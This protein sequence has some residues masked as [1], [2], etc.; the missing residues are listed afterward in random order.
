MLWELCQS[1]TIGA[2]SWLPIALFPRTPCWKRLIALQILWTS[3]RL[4]VR[5]DAVVGGNRDAAQTLWFPCAVD[6]TRTR[7]QLHRLRWL[8]YLG[9]VH[10]KPRFLEGREN[11]RTNPY[12]GRSSTCDSFKAAVSEKRKAS[13]SIRLLLATHNYTN[14]LHLSPLK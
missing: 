13:K 11:L 14:Y 5:P 10:L 4:S 3:C 9:L 8:G 12:H 1:T 6:Q 2:A 7:H